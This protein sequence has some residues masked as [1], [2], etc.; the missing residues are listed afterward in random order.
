MKLANYFDMPAVMAR[1]VDFLMEDEVSLSSKLLLADK[2][3]LENMKVF[4]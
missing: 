1:C 2:F 3:G 4:N